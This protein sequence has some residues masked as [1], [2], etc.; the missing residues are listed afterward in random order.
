MDRVADMLTA[1]NNAQIVLKNKLVYP[2]LTLN[3]ELQKYSKRGL[4]LRCGKKGTYSK[5][6]NTY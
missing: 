6:K 1:I 5:K 3:S 4:Y 2:I